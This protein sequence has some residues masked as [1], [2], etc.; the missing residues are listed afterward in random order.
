MVSRSVS[1]LPNMAIADAERRVRTLDSASTKVASG[2]MIN[3][4]TAQASA[5]VGSKIEPADLAPDAA[6]EA[7]DAAARTTAARLSEFSPGRRCQGRAPAAR[8]EERRVGKERRS[9]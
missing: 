1:T 8:S 2:A 6:P 9:R 5:W 3:A 7:P 4:G